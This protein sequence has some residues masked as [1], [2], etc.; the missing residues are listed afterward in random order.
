MD[1]YAKE[2]CE[3][4][5][6]AFGA[7]SE[8][9]RADAMAKYMRGHFTFL[10][11]P[12]PARR[13]LQ[14]EALKP[15]QRPA[16][17]AVIEAALALWGLPQREYQYA[18]CDLLS[19]NAS[20]LGEGALTTCERL[21][22]SKSWWDTVDA[23]AAH[24]AGPIVLRHSGS[25]TVMDRW[26]RYE[27]MWLRRSAIIHQLRFKERTDTAR[28]FRYVL[29]TAHEPEFFIRKAIGWALRQY[30]WT[31]PDATRQFVAAH[32]SELSPLSKREALLAINGGRKGSRATGQAAE[33]G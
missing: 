18:A 23:V 13:V 3:R 4:L 8:S 33:T 32:D 14:R 2:V 29:L 5:Q 6:V 16:P 9:A 7:A 31:D 22:T 21:L 26:I 11:I 24:V 17:E 27:N 15:L 25:E 30:S 10:G 12:S 20:R 28:L 19:A 1:D